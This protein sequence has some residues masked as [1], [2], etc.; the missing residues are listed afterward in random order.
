M[1]IIELE[2]KENRWILI[3]HYEDLKNCLS[4]NHSQVSFVAM[5]WN[6]ELYTPKF[7][8]LENEHNFILKED[9]FNSFYLKDLFTA[10]LFSIG[11]FKNPAIS[12]ENLNEFSFK[13][14]DSSLTETLVGS[15]SEFQGLKPYKK[16]ETIKFFLDKGI[17]HAEITQDGSIYDP[18]NGKMIPQNAKTYYRYSEEKK[19]FI[20]LE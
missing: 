3:K 16:T 18:E 12:W 20:K 4:E 17:L 13:D 5:G 6:F 15:W 19:I 14:F 1:S 9:N 8:S 10:K 2:F 7:L 11:N